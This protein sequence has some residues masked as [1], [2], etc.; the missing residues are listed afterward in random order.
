MIRVFHRINQAM[1]ED[2]FVQGDMKPFVKAKSAAET[3]YP[4]MK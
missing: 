2:K 4:S 3:M 1:S